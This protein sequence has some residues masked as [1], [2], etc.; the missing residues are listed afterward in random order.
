MRSRPTAST[1]W[2]CGRRRSASIGS[3]RTST[4]GLSRSVRVEQGLDAG[5]E[6]QGALGVHQGE[7]LAAGP[8]VAVLAR[9]GSA[10]PHRQ[11]SRVEDE[12]P[13]VRTAAVQGEVDADMD[14][15]VAE[16][17]VRQTRRPRRSSSAP[18]TLGGRP[19]AE[20]AAR[21]R[22]PSRAR[23]GDP[24]ASGPPARRR[25]RGSATSPSTRRRPAGPSRRARRH[26]A[27]E[28]VPR[29]APPP[30]AAPPSSTISQ[31]APRGSSGT[32]AAPR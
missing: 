30:D 26:R 12:R 22:P 15:P 8:A 13:E 6:L 10:V 19:P 21:P 17:P 24:P 18:R 5:E 3:G 1:G 7:Q 27:P 23:P 14:A 29:P 2:A 31:P 20:R 4:P 11:P 25:P 28:R 32:A 16:M 9:A